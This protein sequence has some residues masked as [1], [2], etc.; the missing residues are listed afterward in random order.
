MAENTTAKRRKGTEKLP[1][2]ARL[3]SSKSGRWNL[4]GR[5]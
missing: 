4:S 1:I 2:N 3:A 5:M